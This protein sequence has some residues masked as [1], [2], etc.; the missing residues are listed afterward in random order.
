MLTVLLILALA[1]LVFLGARHLAKRRK[2]AA[3]PLAQPQSD[4]DSDGGPGEEKP[5]K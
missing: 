5:P 1:V 4:G 2:P 3:P